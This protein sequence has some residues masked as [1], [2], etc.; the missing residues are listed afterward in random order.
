MEGITFYRCE[1]C[2]NIVAL[3]SRGGGS[4]SC[5]GENMTKLEAN[6]TDAS[7]EKHV[8]VA[9]KADGK[10]KA[11]V[12]SAPHP[13]LPEHFIQWVALRAGDRLEIVFL[14]PG[15]EPKAEFAAAESG[16]VYEYCNLHGLWKADF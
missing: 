8:P 7:R 15:A 5:C 13:M 11:A 2:G 3:V 6:T 9:T 1:T 16:T 12:G 10:V 14:K 4:P